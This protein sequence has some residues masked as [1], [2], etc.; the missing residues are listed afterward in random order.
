MQ[1]M[2]TGLIFFD[3]ALLAS[4]EMGEEHLPMSQT[5][6]VDAF[7]FWSAFYSRVGHTWFEASGLAHFLVVES[8]AYWFFYFFLV[9]SPSCPPPVIP[10]SSS[11]IPQL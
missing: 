8:I 4:V 1:S 7:S 11:S 9:S 6:S 3:R 5:Q 2:F 10:S